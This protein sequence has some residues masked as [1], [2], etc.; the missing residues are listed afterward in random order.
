MAGYGLGLAICIALTAM[1]SVSCVCNIF[2]YLFIMHVCIY[3]LLQ[4]T[5]HKFRTDKWILHS[6]MFYICKVFSWLCRNKVQTRWCAS[7]SL[8]SSASLC[9]SNSLM[10]S[11]KDTYSQ[12]SHLWLDYCIVY[13]TSLIAKQ[14]EWWKANVDLLKP[15]IDLFLITHTV[16]VKKILVFILNKQ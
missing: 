14:H 11:V 7:N 12:V 13:T 6:Q 5:V 3:V 8:M 9:A 4:Y 15:W 2:M 10:S 1:Y 16:L